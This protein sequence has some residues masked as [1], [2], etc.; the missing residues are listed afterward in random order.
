[1]EV[2]SVSLARLTAALILYCIHPQSTRMVFRAA[3]GLPGAE[4]GGRGEGGEFS[5]FPS[6]SHLWAKIKYRCPG[7][8][9]DISQSLSIRSDLVI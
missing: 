1:M 8:S 9:C 5:S 4:L 2:V 6:A 7:I 3:P